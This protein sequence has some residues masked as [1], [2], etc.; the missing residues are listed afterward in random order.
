MPSKLKILAFAGSLRAD[1]YNKRLVRLA[2]AAATAAGAE[3]SELDLKDIPLPIF[4]EDLEKAEG[5]PANARKLKDLMLAN[6]GFL[7][8]APEYNSSITAVLKNA[9]DW[10]SRK[11]GNEKPL[12]CFAG[13]VIGLMAAS[14]G[15][16]G[17]L[18]GLVAVRSIFGNINALVIPEQIAVVKANEAFGEDGKLKDAKQQ[19]AVENIAKRVV[20]I[21]AK[22]KA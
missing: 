2:A 9:I 4:D 20:E 3:V 21:V 18:R 11:Q 17:G 16:L 13:K 10:A 8:A 6:D 12:E 1:S 15:A 22:L 7:I 19:A 14:P 5:E